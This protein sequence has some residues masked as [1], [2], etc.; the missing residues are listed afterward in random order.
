MLSAGRLL[1]LGD[2]PKFE[3]TLLL[4]LKT[5]VSLVFES[6]FPD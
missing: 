6:F 2:A 3:L 4:I 1:A 5:V